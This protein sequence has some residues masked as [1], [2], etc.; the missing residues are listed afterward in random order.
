MSVRRQFLRFAIAGIVGFVVDVIVLY[1]LLGL[2]L[3]YYSGRVLS[4][5]VAAFTTWQINRRHAFAAQADERRFREWLRY[6]LAMSAGG[7]LNYLVYG[8]VVVLAPHGPWLPLLA[9]AAGSIAG[10]AANF[11]TAKFWVFKGKTAGT[12]QP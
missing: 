5:L 2:G 12:R 1:V 8:G 7:I 6:L 10:L 3:G 4:F 9:V 11:L